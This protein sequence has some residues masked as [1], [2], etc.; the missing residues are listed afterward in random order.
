MQGLKSIK[1]STI[2]Q[3]ARDILSLVYTDGQTQIITVCFM[4]KQG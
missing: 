4:F 2:K 1:H 3:M